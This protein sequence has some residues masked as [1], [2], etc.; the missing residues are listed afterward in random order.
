MIGALSILAPIA[1]PIINSVIDALGGL[2]KDAVNNAVDT[3]TSSTR[4][5][6]SD[7]MPSQQNNQITY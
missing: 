3:A 4:I 5:M 6:S 7:S 2:A 1:M